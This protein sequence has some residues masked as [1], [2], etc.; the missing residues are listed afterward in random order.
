MKKSSARLGV[1]AVVS[2]FVL[3]MGG[4]TAQASTTA[5]TIGDGRANNGPAVW[6]VQHS[7]NWARTGPVTWN[8][9]A[10]PEISEDGVWGPATKAAVVA[11]QKNYGGYLAVDGYVGQQTG[12]MLLAAGDPYYN[13]VPSAPGY[14]RQY[15]PS[16]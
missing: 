10:W 7:L 15:V 1:A 14:C 9:P 6:C 13:G 5:P 11:F 3:A 12:E 4:G 16:L 8:N 2:A